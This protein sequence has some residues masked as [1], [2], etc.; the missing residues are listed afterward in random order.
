MEREVVF[1]DYYLNEIYKVLKS[2]KEPLSVKEVAE[3]LGIHRHTAS[4]KLR[5]LEGMGIA[6]AYERGR[7]RVY[8]LVKK[9]RER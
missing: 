4:K 8:E 7:A 5:Q 6:R 1:T 9:E 2:A 3:L